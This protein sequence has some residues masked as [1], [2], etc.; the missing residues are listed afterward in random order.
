MLKKIT[1]LSLVGLIAIFLLDIQ[2]STGH[3]ST[4][5]SPGSYSGSPADG[6]KTCATGC[7]GGT[8]ITQTGIISTD[9]PVDGYTPGT[10]YTI[11]LTASYMGRTKYGFELGAAKTS[12]TAVGGFTHPTAAT[13]GVNTNNATHTTSGTAAASGSRT[14]TINWTAPVA[15]SGTITF[16]YALNATNSNSSSSGDQ[17]IRSTLSV[18][19]KSV[20]CV[21]TDAALD[22]QTATV[23]EGQGTNILLSVS[24]TGV[25]YQLKNVSTNV[26][27]G[28]AQNG[29]GSGLSFATGA[30]SSNTQFKILATKNA[31]C[32]LTLSDQPTVSVSSQSTPTITIT[33]NT[34]LCPGDSVVLTSSTANSYSWSTGANTQSIVVKTA[35]NYSVTAANANNCTKT[36]SVVNVTTVSAP[37]PVI[38]PSGTNVLCEG[39]SLLLSA[40][41]FSSYLWS[42]GAITQSI[43]VGAAGSYSVQVT[44]VNGCKGSSAATTVNL[45]AKPQTGIL[46][47]GNHPFCS[48]DS[49]QLTAPSGYTYS[50]SNG[51][52]TQSIFAKAAGTYQ[53]SM[54]SEGCM[55]SDSMSISVFDLPNAKLNYSDT[56]ELCPEDSLSISTLENFA[57]Y[58]WNTGSTA[59]QITTQ[60]PGSYWVIVSDTNGCSNSSDTLELIIA[61]ALHPK[62]L[63]N[64]PLLLCPGAS[65]E[66]STDPFD[67]YLWSNGATSA[68]ITVNDSGVYFVSVSR[69]SGC[70]GVSDTIFVTQLAKPQAFLDPSGPVSACDSIQVAATP[71]FN[72][73]TWSNGFLGQSIGLYRSGTYF[74]NITDSNGCEALSDTLELSL[75]NT[76]VVV[77]HSSG[78]YA[79]ANIA[80]GI[81]WFYNGTTVPGGT[82]DSLQFG[83]N[84][85]YFCV[86]TDSTGLCSDTSNTILYEGSAINEFIVNSS[87]IFPNPATGWLFYKSLH[88]DIVELRILNYLGQE[89]KK[90]NTRTTEGELDISKLAAG[91]YVVTLTFEGGQSAVHLFNVIKND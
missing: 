34:A 8:A 25:S 90:N 22:P 44:N 66:L 75:G 39:D 72:S 31:S 63:A 73:Y 47:S 7:H 60:Q 70:S 55:W 91:S 30:L 76:P 32:S 52:S 61:M 29:T 79:I 69:N 59:A 37:N 85:S 89:V 18:D 78:G 24:E 86:A 87:Q 12:G 15:G 36:S 45:V 84:G 10:Q 43:K 2:F 16:Y 81:Q 68:S 53:V 3:T 26:N 13:K 28:A 67:S 57:T 71:G 48:G 51:A 83:N 41:S 42:N 4:S 33:G 14:W 27:I 74:V 35:G 62:I 21:I 46:L 56:A 82:N 20:P 5:G 1:G 9:I 17:I 38:S 54:L 19:E 49:V 11:T 23:C 50:W 40:G 77:I 80:S 6:N 64:G 65:V 88:K 58:S